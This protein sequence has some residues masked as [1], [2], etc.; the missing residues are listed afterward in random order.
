M[1]QIVLIFANFMTYEKTRIY[2]IRSMIDVD[3]NKVT[4]D[5]RIIFKTTERDR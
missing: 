4:E 1:L 2:G 5:C 3:H